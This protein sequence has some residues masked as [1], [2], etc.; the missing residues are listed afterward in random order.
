VQLRPQVAVWQREVPAGQGITGLW[1]PEP[2]AGVAGRGGAGGGVYTFRQNGNTLTGTI[3]GAGGRGGAGEEGVAIE[4]GKV[5]GANISFTAG[6][7]SYSGTIKGD[8]VEIL[9]AA[10]TGRGGGG[11]LGQQQ[12]QA[13]ATPRPAIGP[14]PDGSDPSGLGTVLAIVGRSGAGRQGGGRGMPAAPIVLRR[15]QR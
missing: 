7:A 12:Q 13:S 3:E 6:G 9:R 14:P 4:N 2:V 10:P 8:V 1:R 15:A 11:G 5:D